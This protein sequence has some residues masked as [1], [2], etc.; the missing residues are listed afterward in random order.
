MDQATLAGIGNVYRAEVLFRARLD[1]YRPGRDVDHGTWSGIWSDLVTLMRAGVRSG[2]IVT[3]EPEHRGRRHG[4]ARAEDAH[5]TYRR[6]GLPCRLCGTAVG[7]AVLAA[8]N[9]YWCGVCQ[10]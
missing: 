6:A 7:T 4:R 3:T 9:L 5:Y 8:R 10:R 2:R 1:P